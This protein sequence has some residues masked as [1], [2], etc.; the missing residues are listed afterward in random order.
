MSFTLNL[1]F[2][3]YDKKEKFLK[4]RTERLHILL[5]A[6]SNLRKMN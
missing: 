1:D 6:N 3:F 2:A 4:T 5:Y